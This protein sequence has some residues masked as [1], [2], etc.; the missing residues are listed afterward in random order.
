LRLAEINY[1]SDGFSSFPLPQF[2][3]GAKKGFVMSNKKARPYFKFYAS[4]WI[5][6]PNTRSLSLEEK[7]AFIELLCNMWKFEDCRLPNDDRFLSRILNIHVNKWRKI[8]PVLLCENFGVLVEKEGYLYSNRLLKEL[9]TIRDTSESR[10][11]AINKRWRDERS[12][13]L[14][15]KEVGDTKVLQ[16]KYNSN[17]TQIQIQTQTQNKEHYVE[18][19]QQCLEY[20]NV[21][22]G[23]KFSKSPELI[24]RL[25]DY[26]VDDV[27]L[28]IDYKSKEWMGGDMQKYLR[29]QTLFNTNKF[30]SYYNDAKQGVSHEKQ[31]P[32]NNNPRN[33]SASERVREK[34]RIRLAELEQEIHR[35]NVNQIMD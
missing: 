21:V 9:D 16:K 13:S 26:S 33:L 32:N 30:E 10:T 29:P 14:K 8:K 4:D 7:G 24:A 20:L 12:K 11:E 19:A 5:S 23:R 1:L 15:N 28:V 25:K 35:G 18:Q 31:Q 6:H 27:K 22:T 3:K 17:T 34:G 2:L